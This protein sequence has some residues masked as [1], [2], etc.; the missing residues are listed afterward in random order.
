M[1][2]YALSASSFGSYVTPIADAALR[3]ARIRNYE[4]NHHSCMDDTEKSVES[5]KRVR[6]LVAAGVIRPVSFHLPFCGGKGW[7]PSS[8]DEEKRKDVSAR[9]QEMLR[10]AV[11]MK[12]PNVTLHASNEPPLEEHPQR[13]GQVC[14]TIEEL[15][16]LAEE[17]HFSINVEFLPRRCVGNCVEELQQIVSN[18]DPEYVG[19]C[20]DVNH[21]MNRY[22]ELPQM[23]DTLA[24]RIRTFHI[25]DYDGVDEMHWIP[26]QGLI[27]WPAVLRHI[28]AIDHD[29]VLI[30]ETHHQLKSEHREIDPVFS[31]RQNEAAC[32]YLENSDRIRAEI[33]AFRIPGNN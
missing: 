24:P 31:L 18:F 11:W 17:Q 12:A 9:M 20:F 15:L 28:K 8:L 27:D 13:I 2:T 19:I 7:D 25:S 22:R 32:W 21:I 26:G 1:I 29:V 3:R 14:K 33:A 10:K 6:Q 30:L 23:I 4:L 5:G 16:P